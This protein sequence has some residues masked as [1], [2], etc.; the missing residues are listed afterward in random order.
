MMKKIVSFF[1]CCLV[2][3]LLHHPQVFASHPPPCPPNP[4]TAP[5]VTVLIGTETRTGND[6]V[7]LNDANGAAHTYPNG[8]TIA[9]LVGAGTGGNAVVV[10][11]CDTAGDRL[12]LMNAKITVS[13]PVTNQVIQ[14]WATF[15]KTPLPAGH[16]AATP[17]T[18]PPVWYKQTGGG[19]I[20]SNNPSPAALDKI[21]AKGD[22]LNPVPGGTWRTMG[23]RS[24]TV[25]AGE[26]APVP[27]FSNSLSWPWPQTPN[28]IGERHI[29]GTVT[30]TLK[31]AADRVELGT[32]IV[33]HNSAAACPDCDPGG[34]P[35]GDPPPSGWCMTTNS[36]ARALGCPSCLT[37]DGM[38]AQNKKLDLF[39]KT[40]WSNLSEDMARGQGEHLAA[41]ASL[42]QISPKRQD[43]FFTVAQDH[44]G[45]LLL[46]NITLSPDAMIAALQER[47]ASQLL[48]SSSR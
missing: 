35:G 3:S 24:K 23:S 42:M 7:I 46:H 11:D 36:T 31:N 8:L 25:Q 32:G 12:T 45:S 4:A 10:V 2:L 47:W 38:V 48:V 15:D 6:Q 41:L 22:I 20:A 14:Y 19:H 26:T 33:I 18:P 9:P 27:F 13:A 16:N 1:S 5:V 30:I 17:Q 40:S 21:V 39:A 28:L 44:Y 34:D 29:R 37:E 43:E